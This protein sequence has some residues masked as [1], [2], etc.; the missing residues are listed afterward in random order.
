MPTEEKVLE[1]A[2]EKGWDK[3]LKI[4]T[5]THDLSEVAT[6]F[7]TKESSLQIELRVMCSL[8]LIRLIQKPDKK[9]AYIASGLGLKL[10]EQS[11]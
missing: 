8:K 9:Y 6:R 1:F 5:E 10:L 3:L 4:M 2:R 11:K 7:G